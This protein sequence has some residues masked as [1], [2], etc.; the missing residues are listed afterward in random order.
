MFQAVMDVNV[1]KYKYKIHFKPHYIHDQLFE[2]VVLLSRDGKEFNLNVCIF[3]SLSK[4][5]RQLAEGVSKGNIRVHTELSYLE[6]YKVVTFAKTGCLRGYQ[7]RE[8]LEPRTLANFKDFG[9]DLFHLRFTE[10]FVEHKKTNDLCTSDIEGGGQLEEELLD[11]EVKP[12]DIIANHIEFEED[13][14]NVLPIH[15]NLEIEENHYDDVIEDSFVPGDDNYCDDGD[16]TEEEKP[17]VR[18]V[19]KRMC[20]KRKSADDDEWLPDSEE[21]KPL[22]KKAKKKAAVKKKATKNE[23]DKVTPNLARLFYF[24]QDESLRKKNMNFQC[25]LCVKGFKKSWHFKQHVLRH[26]AKT[27]NDRCRNF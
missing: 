14:K 1:L 27:E 22:R 9:V 7:S 8:E 23:V 12:F 13:I 20:Q 11:I 5:C 25:H 21:D 15:G 16:M 3:A 2:D 17:L 10:K 24:P 6:L 26:G 18:T 4:L 19:P